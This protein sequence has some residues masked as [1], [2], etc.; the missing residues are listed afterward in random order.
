[1][2]EYAAVAEKKGL[3]AKLETFKVCCACFF[4]Q[5]LI[6]RYRFTVGAG[7]RPGDQGR[8]SKRPQRLSREK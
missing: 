8:L 2:E 3:T 7:S 5:I 1:M 4:W 6:R